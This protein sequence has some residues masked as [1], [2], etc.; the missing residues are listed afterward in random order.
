MMRI[1]D[2]AVFTIS[3]RKSCVVV[4]ED[5]G[6]RVAFYESSGKCGGAKKGRW[7]PFYGLSFNIPTDGFWLIKSASGKSTVPGSLEDAMCNW[8]T[9][10]DLEVTYEYKDGSWWRGDAD[11][12]IDLVNTM[13]EINDYLKFLGIEVRE[14]ELPTTREEMQ[15]ILMDLKA[16]VRAAA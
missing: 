2:D 4:D 8:L 6:R 10:Q 5:S 13:L 9:S 3:G 12:R 15:P 16:K 7:V 1:A 14:D 11:A